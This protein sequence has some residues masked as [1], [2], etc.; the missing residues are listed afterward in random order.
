MVVSGVIE[1]YDDTFA[2]TAVSKQL[3]QKGHERFGIEH[4]RERA[5][6]APGIQI[7]HAE[8]GH[9]LS[10]GRMQHDRVARLWRYP[11]SAA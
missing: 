5:Y 7:D 4:S 6:Q 2:T 3:A 11:H 1:H 8:A 10:G 9:G